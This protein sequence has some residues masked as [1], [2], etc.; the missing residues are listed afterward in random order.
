M[1]ATVKLRLSID[2]ILHECDSADPELLGK[3][4]VE[5]F[6]RIRQITPATLIEFQAAPSWLPQNAD[7]DWRPDWIADS[8]VIGQVRRITSPRDLVT[9]LSAQLDE[10]EGLPR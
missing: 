3:W 2:G 10:Y 7:G 9:E 1:G 8:R 4:I 5:I 6:G